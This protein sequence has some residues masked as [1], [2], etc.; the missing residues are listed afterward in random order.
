MFGQSVI[1]GALIIFLIRV[2]SIA[3]STLRILLMSRV[4]RAITFIM[5]FLEALAFAL[6]ISQVASNL[7]NIW[8]LMAYSVGYAV[9][10]IV[11]MMIEERIATGYTTINVVSMGKSLQITEAVRAAGYGATRSSGEGTKGTVGLIR[12]VARRKNAQ[13]I[14]DIIREADPKAFVTLE[15]TRSVFRGFLDDTAGH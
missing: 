5:A 6:T 15:E 1:V 2:A 8:N 4:N 9:G 11:G 13:R 3:V 14:A 10:T 12:V 7:N